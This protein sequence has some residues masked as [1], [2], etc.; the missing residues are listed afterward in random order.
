MVA[1]GLRAAANAAQE[2]M[3]VCSADNKIVHAND[4]AADLFGCP[5]S[6]LVGRDVTGLVVPKG[7]ESE[8]SGDG[9]ARQS[10]P[11]VALTHERGE[12]SVEEFIRHRCAVSRRF[13]AGS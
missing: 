2:A 13:G 7:T 6:D 8:D 12:V 3:L 10:V 9:P 4:A 1:R 5:G 11:A